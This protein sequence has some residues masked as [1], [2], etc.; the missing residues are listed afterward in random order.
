MYHSF[1]APIVYSDVNGQYRGLDQNIYTADGFKDYT[2]FS[3]WDTYRALHPLFTIIQQQRTNDIINSMLLHYEQSVH[4]ILPIWSHYSNENWCMIGYHSVAVIVDAYLKGITGYNVD[5]ALDA[6]V[7]SATYKPYDGIGYYEKYGYVPEDLNSNSA[8]KTLEYAFDDWTISRFA[9][10]LG[11]MKLYNEFLKRAESYKKIFDK[12]TGFMRAKNSDGSWKAEFN[13]LSTD[14]QGFIEGNS[15]N[16]SLYVPQDIEGFIKLLGGKDKLITWLD[17]LFT[18][19]I[20]DESIAETEDV[21]KAGMIGNYVHGNEPSHHVPY[22]Y[23]YAGEPWRTQE[24]IHQI[25]DTM[26]RS[27]PDGL[28]GNDDCGQ[29]SAWYIFSSM[30]FYPVA[31]GSNQYVFGSPC[32]QSAVIN[33]E[34]GKQFFIEAKN[35][36]DKNIYIQSISLN[37]EDYHNSFILH[38]D[39]INGGKLVFNMSSKP[40]KE[41]AKNMKLP[42]S[43]SSDSE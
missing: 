43:M 10:T 27:K 38:K 18:M 19:K 33:L 28:C 26:Y 30:G 36:S 24:R 12:K 35:L 29:M 14:G 40:N 8:S 34:N 11:K 20:S 3:L 42:Y 21:T 31:P 6:V 7:A 15:W 17:S 4:K 23:V 22:M 41:W 39:I 32:V 9:K 16:Y 2:I 37:G 13:P 1:L 25:V 5:E